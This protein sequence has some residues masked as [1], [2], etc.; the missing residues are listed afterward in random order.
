MMRL[1]SVSD[2]PS[3]CDL[4]IVGAGPAGLAAAATAASYGLQ[5]IVFDENQEAGGQIYRAIGSAPASR[6]RVLG[7]DYERGDALV[8]AMQ[9]SSASYLLGATVWM[10]SRDREIGVSKDGISRIV[11][12]RHILFATGALERPFPIEGWTLPGVLT[13]GAAQGALKTSGLVPQGRFV[14]AGTGPL[15][16]L[17]ASQLMAAD[18]V[19]V[20]I[21]DTTLPKMRPAVLRELP[22]FV[23]SP[24]MMKGLRLM[25]EVN[26]R[27]RVIEGVTDLRAIGE[28]HLRGVAY[29]TRRGESATINVDVLLLHQG[30]VPNVNMANAAGCE[31]AWDEVQL[32][33]KPVTDAW[34][35]SSLPGISIAGDGAGIAGAEAAACTGR[36]CALDVAAQLGK[37]TQLERDNAA[38]PTHRELGRFARGRRFLD[39]MFQP[40]ENFRRAAPDSTV[41]RCEEVKGRQVIEAVADFGAVGPNQL[42]SY[43]RCG[44]GPCQGRL[45]GLTVTEMIAAERKVSPAEVG[46]YRL[47]FPIKPLTVAEIAS[48][49]HEE[50]DVR[51]VVRI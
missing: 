15:L 23:R 7:K 44:M 43:L 36:L 29:R 22:S 27:T 39:L 6:R 34:G 3:S 16:W 14:L 41:C 40:P 32:C 46:Y 25:R 12:A 8:S 21:L 9:A 11:T 45:C 31:M 18:A 49:P 33:W 17:L 13:A 26:A 1:A 28:G 47:R 4:A 37:V 51:A 42:K 30:V 5:V 19:P 24:Y 48:L 35:R 2:L 38:T 10:A 50:D 20:A